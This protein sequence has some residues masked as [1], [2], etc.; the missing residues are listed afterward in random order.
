MK[1][2]IDNMYIK[3]LANNL[4]LDECHSLFN[5]LLGTTKCVG[6]AS[7]TLYGQ[8][9]LSLSINLS[10]LF[11]IAIRDVSPSLD[12]IEKSPIQLLPPYVIQKFDS[13]ALS[14]LL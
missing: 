11:T 4:I 6:A 10:T 9:S 8:L 1:K 13:V 14:Y 12:Y 7:E 3:S 5:S 2:F